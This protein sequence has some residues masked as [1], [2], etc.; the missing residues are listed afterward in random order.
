MITGAIAD[1][2]ADESAG[3]HGET[4]PGRRA[5]YRDHLGYRSQR[6]IY[7]SKFSVFL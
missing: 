3:F 4:A 1:E 6:N 5:D 7:C 2:P